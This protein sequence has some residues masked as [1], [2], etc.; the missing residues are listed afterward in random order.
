MKEKAVFAFN[1]WNMDSARA[2]IDAAALMRKNVILQVSA[3]IYGS[4]RNLPVRE[5]I[6]SYAEHGGIKAWLHLDHCRDLEM[7][8]DAVKKQWDSVMIDASQYNIDENI[9]IVNQVVEVA[10]KNGVAV[11]AEVGKLKGV[12]EDISSIRHEIADQGEIGKFLNSTD[13][14]MIAVAFGN[15]HGIYRGRPELDYELVEFTTSVSKAPFVV[16]GGSGLSDEVL[17]RLLSITGVKKINISTD[18]KMSYREGIMRAQEEGFLKSEGFQAAK[19]DQCI[20][21]AIVG[22]VTGK[23]KLL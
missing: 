12:E 8:K 22:M 23:L 13:V 14:D 16:H 18:V 3:S 10:H 17:K 1:I 7:I 4:I 9:A 15:T 6:H 20:H 11:E 21:D 5:F 19:V 2:V